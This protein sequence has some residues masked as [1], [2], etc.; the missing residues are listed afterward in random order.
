[1]IIKSRAGPE[2]SLDSLNLLLS[3]LPENV[4]VDNESRFLDV[5]GK[6]DLL[7]SF[8]STTIEEAL[9]NDIPVLLYGGGGRYA[10]I[11]VA[12]YKN[13]DAIEKAVT[14]IK[15]KEQLIDYFTALNQKSSSFTVPSEEFDPYRFKKGDA[16]E[17]S[18]WF[19]SDK[20]KSMAAA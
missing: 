15:R 3:P 5:L 18:D 10:H 12:P 14:F 13:G 1:M 16:V 17:F 9:V 8:S 7:I 6:A 2:F 4:I 20:I 11:P 19:F